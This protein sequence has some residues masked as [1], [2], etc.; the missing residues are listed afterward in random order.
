[1]PSDKNL[2]PLPSVSLLSSWHVPLP[3]RATL[4][5]TRDESNVDSL[6]A[7]QIALRNRIALHD[8]Y[9]L[10]HADLPWYAKVSR[11]KLGSDTTPLEFASSLT[12]GE[13]DAI[14]KSLNRLLSGPDYSGAL[15]GFRPRFT[16]L[17]TYWPFISLPD[18]EDKD[19]KGK[20][21]QLWKKSIKA[22]RNSLY[23]ASALGCRHVEIVGGSSIPEHPDART[24][25]V[26]PED[27]RRKRMAR[28]VEGLREVF[29]GD[30]DILFDDLLRDTP[31]RNGTRAPFAARLP[32]LCMEIEPGQSYLISKLDDFSKLH[33]QIR[34][35][36]G[37]RQRAKDQLTLNA[38]I[39]HIFLSAPHGARGS[40]AM[41]E[42]LK[43]FQDLAKGGLVGHYHLSD[44]A[45]SH[46]AD[47]APGVYHF[48][49][50]Y[51]PWL[52]VAIERMMTPDPRFSGTIAIELEGCNDIHEAARAIGKVSR[53]LEDIQRQMATEQRT[54]TIDPQVVEGALLVVDIG[55]STQA[56]LGEDRKAT[57]GGRNLVQLVSQIC[58]AVQYHRG[59]VLSFTGD[60]LIALFEQSHY[61]TGGEAAQAALDTGDEIRRRVFTFVERLEQGA[62]RKG[63]TLRAGLH[64]GKIFVPSFGHLRQQAIGRDVVITSR[65][66]DWLS[67]Q[68]E[69]AVPED[70][71]EMLI[72]TTGEFAKRFTL[73]AQRRFGQWGNAKFKGIDDPVDVWIEKPYLLRKAK[74]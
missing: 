2:I 54:P 52:R 25:Q 40:E 73:A 53:W 57:E 66:C 48:F 26:Q 58:Q 63:I 50:D 6:P 19:D 42:K 24:R 15:V 4:K 22:I 39:A 5:K 68:V 12:K 72:A 67:K 1:M 69:P 38:D 9:F 21:T 37:T 18:D 33:G 36:P 65:L 16:A 34:D 17:A 51:E 10:G 28:L 64:F 70:A 8:L 45:R 35:A 14:A 23:L 49:E 31:Q 20:P 7:L 27:Y 47:L 29:D 13:L 46:A 60:G 55:N 62:E 61:F 43:Q 41:R 11:T 71:R 32:F 30:F 56:F 3:T 59:S 74:K 44:H